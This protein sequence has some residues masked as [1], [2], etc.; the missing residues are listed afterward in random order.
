MWKRCDGPSETRCVWR[1]ETG[2]WSHALNLAYISQLNSVTVSWVPGLPL[3]L[4]WQKIL[5]QCGRPGSDPWVGKIPWRRERLPT[6]VFWPGEFHGL[7][8]SWGRKELDRTER[9]SLSRWVPGWSGLGGTL[10][11]KTLF[12][13]LSNCPP[14]TQ[15]QSRDSSSH[16]MCSYL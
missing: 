1:R 10:W 15:R 11:W 8:S 13:I 4:S 2:F 12:S 14:P 7:F 9:L 6:P 5:L 16:Q 3:W